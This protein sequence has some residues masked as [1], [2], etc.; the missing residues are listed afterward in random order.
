MF[1]KILV[2]PELAGP[3]KQ[4]CLAVC[5][6]EEE[7][8]AGPRGPSAHTMARLASPYWRHREPEKL[9]AFLCWCLPRGLRLS[10]LK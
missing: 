2:C 6:S 3:V 5:I 8:F 10:S 9:A 7:R 4:L 1:P